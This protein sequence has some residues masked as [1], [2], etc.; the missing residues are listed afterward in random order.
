MCP[1]YVGYLTILFSSSSQ[2]SQS[3]NLIFCCPFHTIS[4]RC[5]NSSR[6]GLLAHA[7]RAQR[8]GLRS[9][10]LPTFSANPGLTNRFMWLFTPINSTLPSTMQSPFDST[11]PS[12]LRCGEGMHERK[13][14]EKGYQGLEPEKMDD[15]KALESWVIV[16]TIKV[17]A[18]KTGTRRILTFHAP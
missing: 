4:H 6:H 13:L 18:L 2:T 1:I 16:I 9:I 17:R 5:R 12:T 8:I 3:L 14:L 7:D 11:L 10:R 15:P